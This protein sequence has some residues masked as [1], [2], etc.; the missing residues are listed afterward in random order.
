MYGR[1]KKQDKMYRPVNG[2]KRV[3]ASPTAQA[4]PGRTQQGIKDQATQMKVASRLNALQAMRKR[5]GA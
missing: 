3:Q 4:L 1:M 2:G 5:Q